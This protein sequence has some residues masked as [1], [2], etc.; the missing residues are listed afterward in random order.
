MLAMTNETSA[1][2][3]ALARQALAT[4]RP[5]A[6]GRGD[7]YRVN[8]P[9]VEPLWA[10]IRA[11][12]SVD[13]GEA[14]LVDADGDAIEEMEAIVAGIA[15]A[16]LAEGLVVD[17]FLTKQALQAHGAIYAWPDEMP[18]MG[19]LVSVRRPGAVDPVALKER[20]FETSTFAPDDE[21]SFVAIDLLWLDGSSLLDVPL[22]ERRR[23]LES[24]LSESEI[25][26]LGAFV[27]PPIET[28]VASWRMQGFSG[29]T[30][31]AANSRYLPGK[32]NPEWAVS[33]MPR[34]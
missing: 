15:A 30:F 23:L 8:D 19:R 31:K 9:I 18:S 1:A 11:L 28:W 12:A 33:G 10:G 21:I 22:L 20:D 29:V 24:V 26:R 7:P 13:D 17:G 25:V 3:P 27:R 2:E 5:Q 6:F 34:R 14:A 16:A 32:P 4:L